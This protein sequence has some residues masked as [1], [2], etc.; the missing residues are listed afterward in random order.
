M[1]AGGEPWS[2][3]V[4]VRSMN[5]SSNDSGSIMGES[6]DM[7]FLIC[8]DTLTYISMRGGTTTASG[9]SFSALNMGMAECT[10]LIRAI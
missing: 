5:A 6:S 1:I 4:P 7:N 9:H 10:P 2:F 8:L 3:S